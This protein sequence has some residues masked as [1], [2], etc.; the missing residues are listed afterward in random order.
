MNKDMTA[1]RA[2]RSAVPLSLALLVFN[3][4]T[5]GEPSR[6]ANPEPTLASQSPP[7]EETDDPASP[8]RRVC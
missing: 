3:A 1:G 4:L 5:G 8:P 7:V 6:G 2:G